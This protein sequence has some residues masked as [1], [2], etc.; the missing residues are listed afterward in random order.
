MLRNLLVLLHRYLGLATALF[1]ALAGITGSVLAFQHELD[2]WLN[3]Q[4][5]QTEP[6]ATPRLDG[7]DLVERLEA[8]YP[9]RLVWYLEQ[10]DEAGHSALLATVPRTDPATGQ[11]YPLQPRVFYL[12]PADGRILGER[13]WGA[14]CFSRENLVPFL[15]TFHYSLSLPGN[16]GIWLMGIVAMLWTLDCLVSLWL[17]LPRGRSFWRKWGKAWTIKRQRF[18]HD[19]HRAGGLWLWLLLT[20]VALSSVAMNLPAQVFK[21]VVSLFSEVPLSTY[22]ARGRLPKAQLGTLRLDYRQ[23]YRLAREE[24]D[25]LGLHA[26]ITELYYSFEYNF[27]GAGFGDHAS[28]EGNAWVFVDGQDGRVIGREIPGVGSLGERFWQLQL[29]IHG[30]RILGLPGR[31]AIAVLGV[32][33]AVLSV[34]GVVIWWRKR[35]ARRFA[36]RRFVDPQLR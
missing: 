13:E 36:A 34:T 33:I 30:G 2:E 32:A 27:F 25:R 7:P 35:R 22:E 18:N 5:Y 23:A 9:Q 24:G 4:F 3:P 8:R 12:D 11:P 15:L 29:P 1:L 31:I 26:P 6:G 28:D 10:P 21:P 20:P 19:L 14:C 17:T 16:W